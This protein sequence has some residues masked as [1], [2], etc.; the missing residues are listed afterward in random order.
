MPSHK[1]SHRRGFW[2][3]PIKWKW[4]SIMID[5]SAS[6]IVEFDIPFEISDLPTSEIPHLVFIKQNDPVPALVDTTPS[7]LNQKSNL[8][9]TFAGVILL[10][11]QLVQFEDPV[12]IDLVEVL[13]TLVCM[14]LL[15][16]FIYDLAYSK[17]RKEL[18]KSRWWEPL[19]SIPMID[20]AQKAV[21]GV[22]LLRI[23]RL[24]RVFKLHRELRLFLSNSYDF[25]QK[26]RIL[27][28]SC[29]VGLTI[30]T[31]SL[32]FFYA[33]QGVNPALHSYKDSIW[34]A[35]VTVTTIGYGD[36]YPV[37]TAGRFVAMIMMFIGI[38]CVSLLTALIASTYLRE[39]KCQNCGSDI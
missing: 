29:F 7:L 39:N 11:V 18:L 36:I 19:A 4:S 14:T 3:M 25:L 22:R 9:V 32:G 12:G 17:N 6:S 8:I 15:A 21:L 38:G 26:N 20:A 16:D 5:Q 10:L 31:G 27:D 24:L 35:M 1:S 34:W 2:A 33:E 13:D 37:T 30:L 28:L 23:L